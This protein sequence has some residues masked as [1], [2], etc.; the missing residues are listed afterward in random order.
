MHEHILI[1][2]DDKKLNSLL[3]EYLWRFE[4]HVQAVTDPEA[5]LRYL[6]KTVP[7]LIVLDIMLP[8][9]N[10]FE[11]CKKI[12]LTWDIPIIMLTARGDVSDRIIGLELGADDYLSKPFE[13][14]E[15]VARIQSILRRQQKALKP[16]R[17][18][19]TQL[20]LGAL[21]IDH[22]KRTVYL[23]QVALNL[24][25]MEF[26]IL[27][28]LAQAPGRVFSRE[29]LQEKLKGYEWEAFD[30]SIDVLISRLRQKLQ[31]DT[32]NPKYIKTIWGTGYTFIAGQEANETTP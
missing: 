5:G 31:D 4:L 28:F 18:K 14:R 17:Q 3:T 11:V 19:V 10:G 12:R 24:T 20:K 22:A 27:L 23:D 26:E 13:P 6:E 8:K 1:I 9:M 21:T 30:R 2:D 29:Q 16:A 32:K 25:T 15:L 7:D